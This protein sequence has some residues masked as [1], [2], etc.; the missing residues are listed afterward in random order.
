M[1]DRDVEDLPMLEKRV[2]G[3]LFSD[4]LDLDPRAVIPGNE[5]IG[6][7]G[8]RHLRLRLDARHQPCFCQDLTAVADAQ[9]RL[10]G[11]R[12]LLQRIKERILGRDDSGPDAILEAPSA[13]K[14]IAVKFLQLRV[15]PARNLGVH[16]SRDAGSFGLIFA[17]H[18]REP[19]DS[20]RRFHVACTHASLIEVICAMRSSEGFIFIFSSSAS[21]LSISL[22]TIPSAR[23]VMLMRY[24]GL[25]ESQYSRFSVALFW[26]RIWTKETMHSFLRRWVCS[27]LPS[28]SLIIPLKAKST[29]Y[30]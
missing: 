14:Q 22:Y 28:A 12:L 16:A 30:W 6:I 21:G 23:F 1:R 7:R 13:R 19:D 5:R 25:M 10:S 17:I 4:V 29:A 2:V 3:V 24:S 27:H 15:V 11:L 20:Y 9:H 18:S 8:E 26:M